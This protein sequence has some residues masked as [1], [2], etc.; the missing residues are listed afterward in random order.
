MSRVW[1]AL[2]IMSCFSLLFGL[3]VGGIGVELGDVMIPVVSG[4]GWVLSVINWSREC[5]KS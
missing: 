5:F 4:V 3:S 1:M 2:L